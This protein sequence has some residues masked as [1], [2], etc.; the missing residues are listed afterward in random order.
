MF[1]CGFGAAA[2]MAPQLR[3]LE[4]VLAGEP[5]AHALFCAGGGPRLTRGQLQQE[6]V[7]FANLIRQAGV[8]PG[9]VVSLTD[10]NTVLTRRFVDAVDELALV[11]TLN[12]RRCRLASS[13]R[14]WGLPW[15]GR[16]PPP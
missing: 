3:T 2:T 15:R 4:G 11:V 5:G 13:W 16:W 10:T 14:S 9:D 7:H 1:C 6:I 12:R 8:R